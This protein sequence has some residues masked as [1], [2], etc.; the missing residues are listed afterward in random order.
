MSQVDMSLKVAGEQR[1]IK[2]S[3]V[4]DAIDG[5]KGGRRGCLAGEPAGLAAWHTLQNSFELAWLRFF[6]LNNFFA[7]MQEMISN[8]GIWQFFVALLDATFFLST[9]ESEIW[10]HNF[11][12]WG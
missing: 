2:S 10:G 6:P 8:S 7:G 5:Q 3:N 1:L 12:G 11:F 4:L 9:V